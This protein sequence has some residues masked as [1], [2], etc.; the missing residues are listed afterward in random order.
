VTAFPP[1]GVR[2]FASAMDESLGIVGMP[3]VFTQVPPLTTGEMISEAARRGLIL[4]A[5]RLREL[6][7]TGELVPV[8]EVTSRRVRELLPVP[9]V[10]RRRSSAVGTL[11]IAMS[12]GRLRDPAEGPY[13]SR[14]RFDSRRVTDP[15]GWWNGL[16]Y[17]RWQLLNAPELRDRVTR[18]PEV[19]SAQRRRLKPSQ[20]QEERERA[21]EERRRALALSA[22]DARYYPVV[23][24]GYLRLSNADHAEWEEFIG[25]FDPVAVA[26]QL[27][28]D[29]EEVK[30]H[31]E[32]LLARARA[33]DPLGEWSDLVRRAPTKAREAL[34]GDA[35]VAFENRLA[36]EILLLFYEDLAQRE[37]VPSLRDLPSSAVDGF[38]DRLSGGRD[39]PLD[40]VLVSLGVSSHP[41]VVL[42]VEG[43][44]EEILVPRVFDH[45]Q[46][47]RMPDRVQLL[48]MRGADKELALVAAATAT[49]LLGRLLGD[50]YDLIKPPARLIVAVD[51]DDK[52]NTAA[53]VENERRKML[54]AIGKVLAAQGAQVA[55]DELSSSSRSGRGPPVVSSSPTSQ[56]QNLRRCYAVS[57]TPAADYRSTN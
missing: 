51:Q 49:P 41:G 46:L 45:L 40:E 11:H 18:F 25:D 34:R 21:I 38:R 36:A 55:A 30:L 16:F 22:L 42:V 1:A 13:R 5:T 44:T 15:R 39:K 12:K 24:Q 7:R 47:G 31:A 8:L 20:L 37:V 4:D 48:C 23:D 54:T 10:L 33:I 53:K 56:I 28:I 52:W 17:S 43:E 29:G 50:A 2:V 26:A 35:L 32:R 14:L 19:N 6:Y 3:W 9:P 27:G 57:M